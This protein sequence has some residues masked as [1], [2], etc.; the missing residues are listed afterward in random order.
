M[1]EISGMYIFRYSIKIY[2]KKS[3]IQENVGL[4]VFQKIKGQK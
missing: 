2:L 3:P 4:I 1:D